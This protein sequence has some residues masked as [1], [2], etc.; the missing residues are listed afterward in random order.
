V[1]DQG[2]EHVTSGHEE[3]NH[4]HEDDNRES[5]GSQQRVDESGH[6][7]EDARRIVEPAENGDLRRAR[8]ACRDDAGRHRQNDETD[9]DC[10]PGPFPGAVDVIGGQRRNGNSIRS[11]R[12][13]MSRKSGWSDGEADRNGA[14]V[15]A[16][17][18]HSD[19]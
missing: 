13:G 3:Q 12:I 18:P 2:P 4:H 17:V 6:G 16:L 8:R 1:S 19:C 7:A 5:D 14:D 9:R 11:S 15:K 10:Q